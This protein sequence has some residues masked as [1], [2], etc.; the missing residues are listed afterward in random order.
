[1]RFS[2]DRIKLACQM[3]SFGK[4]NHTNGN[5]ECK[6]AYCPLR[7]FEIANG[8][9]ISVG[10]RAWLDSENIVVR[11]LSESQLKPGVLVVAKSADEVIAVAPAALSK[12]QLVPFKNVKD[13]AASTIYVYSSILGGLFEKYSLYPQLSADSSPQFINCKT[14]EVITAKEFLERYENFSANETMSMPIPGG[15]Y[16]K[17]VN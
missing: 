1:M 11:L 5:G 12:A 15:S 3:H 2:F 10:D 9:L 7:E 17:A 16:I 6:D 13:L 4:C 14:K 8:S